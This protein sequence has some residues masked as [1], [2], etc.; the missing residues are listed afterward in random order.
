MAT[1][2]PPEVAISIEESDVPD[3]PSVN[4]LFRTPGFEEFRQRIYGKSWHHQPGRLG[5]FADFLTW[6]ALNQ[7]LETQPLDPPRVRLAS[8]GSDIPLER[9]GEEID[10]RR[11]RKTVH[12]S[13]GALQSELSAGATLII[14]AI[15]QMHPPIRGLAETFEGAFGDRV[16]VN[17][18]AS[19][20]ETRGFDLHWDDHDVFIF[21]VVGSKSWRIFGT[22]RRFPLRRDVDPNITPPDKPEWSGLVNSGDL[23]YIPRGVWHDARATNGPSLHL[24]LGISRSTGIDLLRWLSDELRSEEVF[25]E[26]L[27]R[28][29]DISSHGEVLF[30]RLEEKWTPDLIQRYFAAS[31]ALRQPRIAFSL[32]WSVTGAIPGESTSFRVRSLVET[33]G[34]SLDDLVKGGEIRLP[35]DGK[36]WSFA[37][38][39]KPILE[40][41]LDSR[42]HTLSDVVMAGR[43][44]GLGLEATQKFI[45]TLVK[46]GL[47][48][49]YESPGSEGS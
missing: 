4:R 47:V 5:A 3:A 21:Q 24:T 15:D 44:H 45:A 2:R 49:I 13:S 30:R 7:L 35:F 9:Y 34:E 42:S 27:P 8:E 32:P 11:R 41:A 20:T 28:I 22:S 39:A 1:Q 26:D 23:L 40:M 19:W 16:Q 17:A 18:Y 37:L 43:Q 10:K 12:V 48:A 33:R 14:D 6:P 29:G 38:D 36:V 25:R 46:N 31:R